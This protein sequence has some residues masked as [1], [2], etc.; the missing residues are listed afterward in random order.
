MGRK[1]FVSDCEGP[2]SLNDN[3]FE[4]SSHF[5]ED[6]KKFF[7]IISKYDDVL[8]DEIKRPGY[9]AGGTLKLIVPFLKAYGADNQKI[10]E[11]SN[12]NVQIINGAD[13]TLRYVTKIMP[14]FIVST[15]YNHYID[16]LCKSTGFPYENTYS[17]K[18]DLDIIDIKPSEIEKIK[19]FRKEIV[20]NPDFEVLEEIFWKKLPELEAGSFM[21]QVQ[22]IGGEGKKDAV[23]DIISKNNLRG[24]DLLYIGDS[25]TDV[26]PL[27]YANN[28]GGVSIAF[29]G[30]E[31]AI[32]EADIAIMAENTIITSIIA[33]LFN[34]YGTDSVME[35]AISYSEDPDLALMAGHINQKLVSLLV[36]H[37]LP[38]VEIVTCN[39]ME[40][41]IEMSSNFR[42]KLRGE[43]IGGLG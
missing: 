42:K 9:N 34:K 15:S 30:N 5:I 8:A 31:F 20:E 3:A 25:I 10:I 32:R 4:L 6:G 14:S 43:S 22:P 41:L 28:E 17:T 37:E 29:N 21:D 12:D 23:M 33:D 19:S 7:Q 36:E 38:E 11:F 2:I 18:L 26:Q 16:A 1:F 24:S 27:R 40:R 13:D 35:F 39:N